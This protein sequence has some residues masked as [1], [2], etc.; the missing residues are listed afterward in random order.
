MGFPLLGLKLSEERIALCFPY[1]LS[2]LFVVVVQV[3]VKI[4]FS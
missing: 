3:V 1:T 4:H 2:L